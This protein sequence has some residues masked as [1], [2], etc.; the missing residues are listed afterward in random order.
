MSIIYLTLALCLVQCTLYLAMWLL[1]R[2]PTPSKIPDS[3]E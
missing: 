2:Q 3:T 1:A